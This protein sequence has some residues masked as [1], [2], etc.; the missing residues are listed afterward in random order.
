MFGLHIA[1]IVVILVYFLIVIGI[2]FWSMRRINNQEDYF[3]AGRRFGKFVQT[4]AAFG[5]AT[6]TESATVISTTTFK[7]GAAGIWSGLN[8]LF[9][10]P[11]YWITSTWYRRMRVLT[12][13]DYFEERYQ[14]KSLAGIYAAVQSIFFM[15][16]LSLSFNAIGKT[17][18]V[19]TPKTQDQLTASEQQEYKRAVEKEKLENRDYASLSP[20]EADRLMQLRIEKPRSVFSHINMNI[21]VFLICLVVLIYAVAGGLEAA[22]L[23]DTLQGV[24]IILIS[25]I[26]IPFAL[27]RTNQVYGGS[28]I[29]EPF[30]ILHAK[31]PES[32][33][34][35]FGSPANID[36][37]WYYVVAV[38][39]MVTLNVLQQANQLTATGSAKGEY[40]AR[41]GFTLGLYIKRIC[42][43]FWGL[44]ALFAVLLYSDQITDPDMVWGYAS[45]DLLGSLNIGLV[46]LMLACMLAALMSTAD[47]LMITA[48]SLI[49]RNVYRPLYPDKQ[50]NHYVM[51][52]RIS[53]AFV[54]IGGALLALYF[55][56]LL[57]QMKLTWEFGIIF[58]APFLLGVVWRKA[59]KRAAWATVAASLMIFFA[60]PFFLPIFL[61]TL[62]TNS[63]LLG[64]TGSYAIEREYTAHEIDVRE[65][66]EMIDRWE[67]RHALGQAKSQRP[68]PLLEG[69]KFVKQYAQPEKSIFWTEGIR[70]NRD[71]KLEGRGLLNLELLVCNGLG[72]DLSNNPYALNETIRIGIRVSVPF[73]LLILL[74]LI[75]RPDDKTALDRFFVK[76]KTRVNPDRKKDEEEI[77][78]SYNNP[79]RF[80]HHK[81]FPNSDWEFCQWDKVDTVGFLIS[82][83]VAFGIIGFFYWIV[84][85][86]RP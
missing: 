23:T 68:A 31:L 18:F 26:L 22:F 70:I 5:Q 57:Q 53:G 58:A 37:T 83:M 54:I 69:Q 62:K 47:C 52:G 65:R 44:V 78:H 77:Q 19:L 59:N 42:T 48:S 9:A 73:L 29:L 6:S 2:G 50:E 1:D 34:D 43:V 79:R 15:L 7:N 25:V 55:D 4:F 16:V 36:F 56:S 63:Y 17:V 30:R 13:A 51:A 3:L 40:E 82:L 46:G 81:L 75:T 45:K 10:T 14:S 67:T 72:F 49:T 80:D 76:M 12:L 11:V 74:S 24:G 28:G 33:F 60:L 61:P 20:Q 85:I 27:I 8:M 64:T 21:L 71:D 41:F 35:I 86:G 39:L 38:M 66:Q 84:S 32:F